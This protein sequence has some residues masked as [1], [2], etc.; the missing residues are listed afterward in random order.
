M[1]AER[2]IF[3]HA[4]IKAAEAEENE[5]KQFLGATFLLRLNSESIISF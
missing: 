4:R 2:L 3:W 5:R 1:A